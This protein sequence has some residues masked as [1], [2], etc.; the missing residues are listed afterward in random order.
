M[1]PNVALDQLLLLDI[2][3]TPAVAAFED[4]PLPIQSLWLEKISKIAPDS[5]DGTGDYAAKAGI[6]AEF[7]KVVCISV[8]FFTLENNQYQLRLKSFCHDD[9]KVV[10]NDFLALVNKFYAR[11]PRFQ[12]AGH[13]IREFDIPYICRRSVIHQ[14]SLPQP[15][16][17][18]GFKPWEV[19][20]LDTLQLWRFG[21]YKN[22]TSLKLLTAILGIPTPKDD[23]DG[24]MVGRVYWQ[25]RDLPRIAAYC[26]KDVL[27][28]AQL[29]LRFKGVP[30]LKEDE[31]VIVK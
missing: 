7:G 10:L 17:L 24:S 1:L 3:T 4:L 26:E 13:N 30:L 12:F 29:V 5:A 16:Q 27:A 25:E 9:E 21:D 14:L 19:P 28:V 22:Y 31:V 23:I 18:H 2:E 20:M 8:G 15:L 6:Y 11:F